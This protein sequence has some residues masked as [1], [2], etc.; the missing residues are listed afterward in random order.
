MIDSPGIMWKRSSYCANNSCVEVG[1]LGDEI[2]MRDAK[3][4][5]G[6]ML[7]FT[8]DEWSAFLSQARDG[9]FDPDS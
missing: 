7:H 1:F 3:D 8:R 4:D 2:V 6:P 9:E 5:R